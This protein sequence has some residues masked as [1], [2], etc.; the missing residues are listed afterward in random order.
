MNRR[1]LLATTAASVVMSAMRT[2]A[3]AS[4]N[5]AEPSDAL[6]GRPDGLNPPGIRVAGIR[7][8]PVVGGKYKVWTKKVGSGPVKVLL[9][10]GGPGFSHEYLEALESFLPRAGIEMYYYDQLG[11]NN[12]DQPDDPSLWTLARYT[13]EVEEVRR[14]LG[15]EHF[16]LYGHSWGG[17]LA[18]EYA[19]H[20]QQNLRGLVISDMTAGTQAYLKRTAYIKRQLPPDTLARL[21]ALEAKEDY[22][23]PEYQKIMM[24][25]LYPKMICRVQPWPEP[26]SRA[27][28]HANNSIYNLMQGKSEFLV[29]GN[30]KNW[31][32]WDRLHEIKVKAL[33]IG[34]R[35]DEMDPEDMK[36][37]ASLMPN[38]SYAYCPN[39]SHLCMW[40]DQETYF[41]HLIGFLRAV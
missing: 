33:T 16:V 17:I 11:C 39:G 21:T 38:G 37:M 23:S 2:P 3:L 8:V 15:L 32:R 1:N 4:S 29:T 26:V 24:E 40:D 7:M 6:N 10:H 14:G 20:Y 36:K 41:K 25:D 13:E 34:A 35:Y 31:E 5:S 28:R 19:L 27:F 30:L 12:S 18:M 22:D 9:L